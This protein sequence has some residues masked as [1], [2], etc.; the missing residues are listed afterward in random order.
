ML[1]EL[2]LNKKLLKNVVL[3]I[4]STERFVELHRAPPRKERKKRRKGNGDQRQ[5]IK[6]AQ[7]EACV[8]LLLLHKQLWVMSN[9]T[10]ISIG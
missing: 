4:K 3:A 10:E 2:Y 1:S 8:Q 7:P 5:Q 9:Y 6:Q